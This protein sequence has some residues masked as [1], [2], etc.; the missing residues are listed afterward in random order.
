M[1]NN[2]Y[3]C[4]ICEKPFAMDVAEADRMLTAAAGAERHIQV[5]TNMRHMR[6][7][8]ALRDIGGHLLP[9]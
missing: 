6:Q 4:K 3:S 2:A 5:G 9:A 8:D 1:E 7:A